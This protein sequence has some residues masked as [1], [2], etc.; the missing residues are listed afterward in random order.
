M[1]PLSLPPTSCANLLRKWARDVAIEVR[2]AIRETGLLYALLLDGD[3]VHYEPIG[4]LVPVDW[5]LVG[6]YDEEAS[7]TD[8]ADDLALMSDREPI[9]APA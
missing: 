3:D 4:R 8:I 7:I 6:V 9:G 5:T 2:D 1:T